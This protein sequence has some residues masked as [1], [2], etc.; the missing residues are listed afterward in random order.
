MSWSHPRPGCYK[1]SDGPFDAVVLQEGEIWRSYVYF[2]GE[3][4]DRGEWDGRGVAMRN[5]RGAMKRARALRSEEVIAREA[6]GDDD[7]C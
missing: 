4:V 2:N 3:E 5:A 1:R 6:D 7:D